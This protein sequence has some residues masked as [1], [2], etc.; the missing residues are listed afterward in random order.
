MSGGHKM[1]ESAGM[2]RERLVTWSDPGALAAAGRQMS[3][4]DYLDAM[5]RGD[6]PMPP[7]ASLL[8]FRITEVAE[9]RVVMVLAPAEYHYNPIGA[10]HGGVIAT[11]LD[12]V[13]GCAVHSRLPAGQGYTTLEIK[14]NYLRAVATATGE[15]IAEGRVLHLGRSTAMAEASLTDGAGR[16]YAHATTTCIILGG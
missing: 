11:V 4:R 12:S 6:L 1:T 16:R 14:V 9:G 3:G 5:R 8:G 10:V 13:M 15:V 7:V 2:S